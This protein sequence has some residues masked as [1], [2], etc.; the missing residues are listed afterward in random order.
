MKQTKQYAYTN[1]GVNDRFPFHC[2]RCG[3]CC[4][5][6]AGSVMAES[7]DLFRLARHLGQS[8]EAVMAQYTVP[9]MLSPGFP[10]L[11]LQTNGSDDACVFL[12][13]N[14]CSI[15][16]AKPRICRMYPMNVDPGED[17]Q[18]VLIMDAYP[19]F[20]G[21]EH[22]A[23]DWLSENF[24][25]EERGYLSL[26]YQFLKQIA[27]ILNGIADRHKDEIVFHMLACRFLNFETA[28]DFLPQYARNMARLKA[29]L[30]RIAGEEGTK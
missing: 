5:E 12:K 10:V 28:A 4:R 22:R 30:W 3:K 25:Q 6:V 21:E 14:C 9:K 27:P 17:F 23:G 8:T 24:T 15:Q 26:E 16:D 11:M 18:G 1:L 2:S 29:E 19:H 7:L 20:H 13:E